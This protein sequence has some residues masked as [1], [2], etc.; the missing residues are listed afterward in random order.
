VAVSVATGA[1]A[2]E[3]MVLAAG[4]GAVTT[5]DPGLVIGFD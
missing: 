1:A 5:R 3:G 2:A 4:R